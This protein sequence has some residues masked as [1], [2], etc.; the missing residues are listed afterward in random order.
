MTLTAFTDAFGAPLSGIPIDGDFRAHGKIQKSGQ[1]YNIAIASS[2]DDS[3][4]I[5]DNFKYFLSFKNLH[6]AVCASKSRGESLEQLHIE[7]SNIHNF[8]YTH[9]LHTISSIKNFKLSGITDQQSAQRIKQNILA[10][11]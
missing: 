8:D 5:K 3:E 1:N 7:L 2:G 4:A 6:I 11:V 9:N 10:Y